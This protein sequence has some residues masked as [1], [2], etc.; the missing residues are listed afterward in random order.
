MFLGEMSPKN[1]RG[2]IGVVPQL[3]ITIGILAA[4]ILGLSSILGNAEGKALAQD[5]AVGST[6]GGFLSAALLCP[7]CR[8]ACAAGAHWD[9]IPAPAPDIA[10]FP[11]ESQVPA[12]PKGQRG[13]GTERY[14]PIL[15]WK[16]R[17]DGM[18][19]AVGHG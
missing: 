9:P 15:A 6:G 11:R 19:L 8:L 13:A 16:G 12:H 5:L 4:Q 17:W 7:R 18:D 14:K 1:L 2:A 10:L 3:F